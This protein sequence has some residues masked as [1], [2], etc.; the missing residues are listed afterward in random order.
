M[1]KTH[2]PARLLTLLISSLVVIG[3]LWIMAQ[4][5]THMVPMDQLMQMQW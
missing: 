1:R 5:S 3:S 4:L 2:V